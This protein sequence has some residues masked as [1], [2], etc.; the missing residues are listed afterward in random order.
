MKVYW[1]SRKLISKQRKNL[2]TSLEW[3][4]S[5]GKC[6]LSFRTKSEIEKQVVL[7]LALKILAL[8][9]MIPF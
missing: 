1:S 9:L 4:L 6:H 2:T 7:L 8:K 3:Q 5:K